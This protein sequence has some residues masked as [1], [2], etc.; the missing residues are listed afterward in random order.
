[1]NVN[2]K[3]KKKYLYFGYLLLVPILLLTGLLAFVT[4]FEY[5]PPTILSLEKVGNAGKEL[6]I[7]KELDMISWNIGYLALE[8]KADFFMD[9][10]KMVR[11]FSEEAIQKNL[12][13]IA[14]EIKER[15]PDILL[16][17]EVDKKS[18][19]SFDVDEIQGLM[20]ALPFYEGGYARNFKAAFVPYPFPPI[21]YVDAGL[22][23]LSSWSSKEMY[24][25]ALSSPFKWPVKTVNLKRCLLVNRIPIKQ[26]ERELVVLNLHLEAYDDTGGAFLQFSEMMEIM[27]NEVEKGNYVIAGGDFNQTFSHIKPKNIGRYGEKTWK[28]NVISPSDERFFYL[29]DEETPSCRSLEKPYEKTE[30]FPKYVIDGFIVSKN[31]EVKEL[32]TLPLDFKNSDH[33]PVYLKVKLK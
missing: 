10:G 18:Y 27:G 19:R 3:M 11:G 24:R 14:E 22:L 21:R 6:E 7:G 17:Q 23:T 5:R 26:S 9:G 15:K 20:A 2:Q 32:R 1:M 31:I 4:I 8:E 30:D 33:N 16:L 25:H 29:M 13:D 28:P 12:S